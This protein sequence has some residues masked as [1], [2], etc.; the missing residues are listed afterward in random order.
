MT[1]LVLKFKKI[2]KDD[3]I[4]YG[5]FYS[6]SKAE[7]II[8][9]N[10]IDDAFKSICTTIM[11]IIQTSL[12]KNSDW[13]VDSVIDHNINISKYNHLKDHPRRGLIDI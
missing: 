13:I 11:S 5:T 1:M 4:K 6:Q 9:G 10:G 8:N 3:K 2:E 7:T 12:G